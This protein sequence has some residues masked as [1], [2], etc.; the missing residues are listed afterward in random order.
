[1]AH[2]IYNEQQVAEFPTFLLAVTRN[3]EFV[4]HKPSFAL[5]LFYR[6]CLK[7]H[8]HFVHLYFCGLG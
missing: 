3:E 4:G 5:P 2:V 7:L 1:M 6:Y 8:L